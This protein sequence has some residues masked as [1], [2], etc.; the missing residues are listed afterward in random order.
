MVISDC[1]RR[2]DCEYRWRF[3]GVYVYRN[4]IYKNKCSFYGVILFLNLGKEMMM[5]VNIVSILVVRGEMVLDKIIK[6]LKEYF[7]DFK[8]RKNFLYKI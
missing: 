5:F 4:D 7:Y 8:V 6:I 3:G 1:R 2:E